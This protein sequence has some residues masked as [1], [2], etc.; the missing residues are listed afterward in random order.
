MVEWDACEKACVSAVIVPG[1]YF[2]ANKKLAVQP[3]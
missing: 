1:C 2:T 3:Q